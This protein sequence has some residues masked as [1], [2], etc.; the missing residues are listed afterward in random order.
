MS[1]A[2]VTM[3]PCGIDSSNV[4]LFSP[5]SAD[6]LQPLVG[7][8]DTVLLFFF[9][10]FTNT[11]FFV[12]FCF[13]V[14]TFTSK[15]ASTIITFDRR[16]TAKLHIYYKHILDSGV[17]CLWVRVLGL[18]KNNASKVKKIHLINF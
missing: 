1:S 2:N 6:Y 4:K 9:F 16:Q 18:E 15:M 12:L 7:L 5:R 14:P 13:L 11:V 10:F 8:R 3:F 17:N